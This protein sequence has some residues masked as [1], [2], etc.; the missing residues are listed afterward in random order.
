MSGVL[1]A[2]LLAF[3]ALVLLLPPGGRDRLGSLAPAERRRLQ[4]SRLRPR[5]RSGVA[6]ALLAAVAT[7]TALTVLGGPV[8]G[9]AAA[10][11]GIAGW[12]AMRRR[13]R[14]KADDAIRNAG[15]IALSGLADDLRAGQTPLAALHTAVQALKSYPSL[16]PVSAALA[17]ARADLVRA[18]SGPSHSADAD[19]AD[20]V[21]ALR[22]VEGP[23][24]PAMHRLAAA[25]A[26]TDS[27]IPLAEVVERLDVELRLQ[28]RAA[29]RAE[30]HTASARM[31]ARLVACLPVLGLGI[32]QLLG[33]APVDVL[34]GTRAGAACALAAVV[35]HLVGFAW[36]SRLG[37]AGT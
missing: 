9:I 14:A 17:A 28:R 23:L 34:T 22:A 30:A 5:G 16:A 31:T 32:G 37:R 33:A 25:W 20:V 6:L 24:A 12:Q 21:G 10:A 18:P 27:G 11:Y 19:D 15:A 35:L 7:F 2:G 3:A 29:E 8:A 13:A 1:G 4:V 26:L 36:A